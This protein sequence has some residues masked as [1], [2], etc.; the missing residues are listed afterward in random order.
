M[1]VG[2]KLE[3]KKMYDSLS[4]R[5]TLGIA[6]AF[7][8]WDS[9]LKIYDYFFYYSESNLLSNWMVIYGFNLP[10]SIF[11]NIFPLLATFGFSWSYI[12]EKNNG[13]K[14]QC[15]IGEGKRKYFTTKFLVTFISGGLVVV[16]P[17]LLNLS[18]M[19]LVIPYEKIE[20]IHIIETGITQYNLWGYLFYDHPIIYIF[21]M[22]GFTFLYSGTIA[23]LSLFVSSFIHQKNIIMIIP[24]LLLLGIYYISSYFEKVGNHILELSPFGWICATTVS[25]EAVE[26]IVIG[27]ILVL[28]ILEII[29]F[30][31]WEANCEIY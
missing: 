7:A 28:L 6:C 27:F 16:I 18:L 10:S 12:Q 29:V 17:I 25:G 24:Y 15:I 13:Y 11:W 21:M 2:I 3:L 22:I 19:A 1:R 5:V 26:I 20:S 14:A 4:F 31:G 30:F 8:I 23:C 9:Y